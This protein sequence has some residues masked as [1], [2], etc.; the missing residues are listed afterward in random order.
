MEPLTLPNPERYSKSLG[1]VFK[2]SNSNGK[3]WVFVEDGADFDVEDDSEQVLHGRLSSPWLATQIAISAVYAKCS[4]P[5]RY[6]LWDKMRELASTLDGCPWMIGGDFNTILSPGDRVGTDTNRQAEMA[7]LAE[8]IEDCRLLDPGFDGAAFTWAK[9]GLFERLDRI[10]V[11]E[12]WT[13][14]FEATRVTNLPR[15]SS[16]HGPILARCKLANTTTTGRAFQFQNMWTRHE[17]FLG[18]VR[19]VWVQPTGAGGLLSLQIKLARVKRALKEW[20]REVFGNI[21]ANVKNM[22]VE[23][24][25]AQ[26]NYEADPSAANRAIINKSIATCILLLKMEEDFWRQ[27]ATMR[28]LAEGDKNTKFCQSWVKQKRVRL[29]IHKI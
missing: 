15:V 8:T 9:N 22:E 3:I 28:W 16:D 20:N 24:A 13:S 27:K 18:L 11:S 5:E 6:A 29:R 25:A 26:A 4:R 14:S 23:I 2:G 1:L 7:D 21:H 17:G 10:L 19:E 12:T